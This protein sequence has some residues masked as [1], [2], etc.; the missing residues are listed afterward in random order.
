MRL[1][2][3]EIHE[4]G[5]DPNELVRQLEGSRR[6]K[7]TFKLNGPVRLQSRFRKPA[8]SLDHPYIGDETFTIGSVMTMESAM[9]HDLEIK[10]VMI[11][12][13]MATAA[14]I[15]SV[16]VSLTEAINLF[17][18]MDAHV[19]HAMVNSSHLGKSPVVS[20]EKMRQAEIESI[21]GWGSW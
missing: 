11:P 3:Q 17:E 1:T 10:L 20:A 4:Y 9:N 12:A 15:A 6:V 21:P 18:G 16:T 13:D 2:Y 5:I 7:R 8:M 19:E 14:K